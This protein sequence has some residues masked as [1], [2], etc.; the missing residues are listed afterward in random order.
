MG[1]K[2]GVKSGMK[3]RVAADMPV[4]ALIPLAAAIV[5]RP[6]LWSTAL[7]LGNRLRP[8]SPQLSTDEFFAFRQQTQVG[9]DGKQPINPHDLVHFLKWAR[10]TR[11]SLS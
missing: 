6:S 8:D 7:R 10:G 11:G 9:G 3:N 4:R 1:L 2:T 5:R